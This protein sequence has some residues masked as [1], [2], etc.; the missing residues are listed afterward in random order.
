MSDQ[1]KPDDAHES[2]APD[3]RPTVEDA[4]A[5]EAEWRREGLIDVPDDHPAP[6]R[7]DEGPFSG[8]MDA[9][10]EVI[11]CAN[12]YAGVDTATP[13]VRE[14]IRL[15][16]EMEVLLRLSVDRDDCL[17]CDGLSEHRSDCKLA[18]LVAT[19]DAARAAGA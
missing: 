3:G 8:V 10:D 13:L 15:A 16:P 9:N 1:G 7:W 17:T 19:I 11:V 2:P 4:V 6:W 5:T 18:A 14:L 12:I